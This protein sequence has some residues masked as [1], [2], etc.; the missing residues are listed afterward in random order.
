MEDDGFEKK[1][2]KKEKKRQR[3]E[4][5]ARKESERST[6]QLRMT[7]ESGGQ[8]NESYA[9]V[10]GND[11]KPVVMIK[12]EYAFGGSMYVNP[13]HVQSLLSSLLGAGANANN[14]PFLIGHQSLI[15]RT[16][17]VSLGG[18]TLDVVPDEN[19]ISSTLNRKPA[20]LMCPGSNQKAYTLLPYLLRIPVKRDKNVAP[21]PVVGAFIEEL[22][23]SMDQ[24]AEADF[25]LKEGPE[26]GFPTLASFVRT[27]NSGALDIAALDCE[28]YRTESGLELGRVTVV[29]D[30]GAVQ[31]DLLVRP[32]N[33]IV[34]YC[35]RYSGLTEEMILGDSAVDFQN[36]QNQFLKLV[37][38][39]TLLIGHSL[40]N[41]LRVL[42]VIHTRI[43]DTSLLYPHP[44]GLPYRRSLKDVT[45]AYLGRLIQQES[46][47]HCS[48]EDAKA[49]LDLFQLKREKGMSFGTPSRDY[50]SVWTKEGALILVEEHAGA[51]QQ[52][53]AGG[54]GEATVELVSDVHQISAKISA[55]L[56]SLIVASVPDG[57]SFEGGATVVEQVWS[58]LSA[59]T[60]LVVCGGRGN[61]EHLMQLQT[62]R[63]NPDDD[64][65]IAAEVNRLRSVPLWVAVK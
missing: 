36:A 27:C 5:E 35:T 39:Q 58:G 64:R 1:L 46:S 49:A 2:S 21:P 57:E 65:A 3:K 9:A 37:G 19:L 42:R 12:D 62:D 14:S 23:V 26:D 40:E 47:G 28:M 56:G 43:A 60:V 53:I 16:V 55:T 17:F 44:R 15:T 31:L 25:P 63:K 6:K 13:N 59:G 32:M 54:I 24:L 52:V 29:D 38:N 61:L 45:Q 7:L 51:L 48:A 33:P 30:K 4:K 22:L 50:Q 8:M 18:V 10:F 34:D 41:D 20:R 11:S